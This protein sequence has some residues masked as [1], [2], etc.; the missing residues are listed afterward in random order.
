MSRTRATQS[1]NAR[2]E[3][4]G[5]TRVP[6]SA[7]DRSQTHKTTMDAGW[8]CPLWI[9]EALPGDTVTVRPTFFARL[10]TPLYPYMDGLHFDYQVFFVPNRLVWDN[11][12]K[13][14][15]E[16]TDPADHNDY[17]V[18]QMV[19]VALEYVEHTIH[20][21]FGLPIGVAGISHSSLFHRAYALIYNE[22]YRDANL[23]DSVDFPTDDGPDVATETWVTLQRRGKRKDYISGALPFAQRGTAVS[24]PLGT[25][26]PII[27]SGSPIQF[28]EGS[29]SGP[30]RIMQSLSATGFQV[31]SAWPTGSTN[32]YSADTTGSGYVADLTA[33]TAA[34]INEIR[35]AISYQHL[36]ERDARGGGRYREVVLSHFGVSTDD[37]RL[38]RPELIA[39][40]SMEIRPT[41][42]ADTTQDNDLGD[43]GAFAVGVGNGRQF[44][45]S[46]T[47]HGMYMLIGS[48]RADLTYQQRVDRMFSRETRFD[49]YWPDLAAIGEQVVRGREVW[50][51][52]VGDPDL[53]TGDFM[54]WGY[55]PRY[56]EYRTRLSQVTGF[57]RS[58][59]ATS[60]DPWHLAIDFGFTRP[61][62]NGTFINENPPV[63]RILASPA[64]AEFLVD[65]YFK[66]THVRPMPKFGTP[67]LVR[68]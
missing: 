58:D 35:L 7:F 41:P 39:S 25:E 44:T 33:A 9:D 67:G 21:Y 47:E 65:C 19:S 8:L 56:E 17:T 42:V 40:G 52:G 62:L 11:F 6:R 38:M 5:P 31:P 26:A 22:W 46:A 12:V 23:I 51:N 60:L 4:V 28:A 49:Y 18:P 63:W 61:S 55:Q 59:S 3:T 29:A 10:A 48:V 13:M 54:V 45:H 50:S 27:S 1:P 32:L 30:E 37:I 43:L 68:F 15:G 64:D 24:L 36:F 20:D 2:F 16:R 34:T 14:M 53:E 66:V 57:F